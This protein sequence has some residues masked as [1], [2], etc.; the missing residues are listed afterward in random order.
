MHYLQKFEFIFCVRQTPDLFV[1]YIHSES[2][3]LQANF[4]QF[5]TSKPWAFKL[6]SQIFNHWKILITYK[7]VFNSKA[8]EQKTNKTNLISVIESIRNHNKLKTDRSIEFHLKWSL[9]FYY[10]FWSQLEHKYRQSNVSRSMSDLCLNLSWNLSC[11]ITDVGEQMI[12][13]WR[14]GPIL[15]LRRDK[16]H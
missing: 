9:V 1:I 4:T 8:K 13:K 7:W 12:K 14:R 6:K 3:L 11:L 15:F 10:W 5:F 2:I 16:T